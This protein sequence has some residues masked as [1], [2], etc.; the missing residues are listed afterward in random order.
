MNTEEMTNRIGELRSE[1]HDLEQKI[2]DNVNT[3]MKKKYG[4]TSYNDPI[5]KDKIGMICE[6]ELFWHYDKQNNLIGITYN[7]FR[8]EYG[9]LND[10]NTIY[11]NPSVIDKYCNV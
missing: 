8:N 1:A 6:E 9:D 7:T 4:V 2:T 3:Y 5:S 11:V 10:D